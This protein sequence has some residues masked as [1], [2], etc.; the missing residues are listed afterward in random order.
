MYKLILGPDKTQQYEIGLLQG[1]VFNLYRYPDLGIN[2]T[3]DW[4][5]LFKT[6]TDPKLVKFHKTKGQIIN[7]ETG[8]IFTFKE[9]MDLI[10]IGHQMID[11]P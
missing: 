8:R 5:H 10:N 1:P 7:E 3:K 4:E 11:R 6:Y 9:I 2:T